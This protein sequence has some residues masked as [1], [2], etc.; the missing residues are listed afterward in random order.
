MKKYNDSWLPCV[1]EAMALIGS[2]PYS[3]LS[4]SEDDT[5]LSN[6]LNH[7]DFSISEVVSQYSWECLL[8]KEAL[9]KMGV[10]DV[11]GYNVFQIPS[12]MQRI[13]SLSDGAKRRGKYIFSLDDEVIMEYVK[14]PTTIIGVSQY[15]LSAISALLATKVCLFITSDK[16]ILSLCNSYYTNRLL[17]AEINDQSYKKDAMEA[18]DGIISSFIQ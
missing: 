2:E 17:Q 5:K 14:M 9:K 1:N 16:G 7:L 10:T 3:T 15:I 6:I 4:P 12:D 13:E 8:E 11:D 18:E